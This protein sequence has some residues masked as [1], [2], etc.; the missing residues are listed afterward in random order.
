MVSVVCTGVLTDCA[1]YKKVIVKARLY[2]TN[3]S[4]HWYILRN[5]IPN[6]TGTWTTYKFV[7]KWNSLDSYVLRALNVLFWFALYVAV[8]LLGY[9]WLAQLSIFHVLCAM[10]SELFLI[11]RE[12][13]FIFYQVAVNLSIITWISFSS[14]CS[15]QDEVLWYISHDHFISMFSDCYVTLGDYLP[16]WRQRDWSR[17]CTSCTTMIGRL[18]YCTYE[19]R[20]A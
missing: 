8:D 16:A 12:F 4:D 13:C 18:K 15:K 17:C 6:R 1:E 20:P 19:E 3:F 11:P 2:N 10:S 14:Y 7:A 9:I 5:M